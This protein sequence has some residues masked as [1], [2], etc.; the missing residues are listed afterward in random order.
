MIRRTASILSLV[1]CLA[2]LVL[3][4][5]FVLAADLGGNKEEIEDLNAQ[6]AERKRKIQQ[7]EETIAQY[8]K[9]IEAKR[10]E[11]VSL[12]NQLSIYENRIAQ[13]EADLE[14]VRN[15]ISEAEMEIEALNITI[16]EKEI[17]ITKQKRIVN[18]MIQRINADD[19]KNYLEIM[20]TNDSFS[21]FY[22]QLKYLENV[23]SDLGRSIKTLRLTREE[24]QTKEAQVQ[25]RRKTYEGLKKELEEKKQDLGEER[26]IRENLLVQTRSSEM[27]YT[28]M[29]G[30][31]KQQYQAIE[32]EVRDYEE[33]VRKKLEEQNKISE[34][35]GN[36]SFSWPVPSRYIT[37]SFHDPDYPYRR[38]FEHSG[39]DIRA[40]QGTPVKAAAAGYIARAKR[41][42][43]ASCYSY[44]LIVHTGNL[45]TVYGHLSSISVSADQFVNKG[46]IIGYSGG[47]PGTVGA[48]PFVTGPHLHFE[49]RA[50]GIPVNPAQYLP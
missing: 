2:G 36:V 29:L 16:K 43:L 25:N 11:A 12:K 13:M 44:V 46:D 32:G 3:A 8:K 23:Y 38:V 9:N 10:L 47:T 37:A 31:L 17:T 1:L 41:C 27:R 20:L 18:K 5:N 24:L 6:I 49:T 45:S 35:G 50:N 28:T 39:L 19:Q 34:N 14:L 30:N 21:D 48:G 22:N 42:S 33:R 7:L 15:K 40:S 4:V 26:N